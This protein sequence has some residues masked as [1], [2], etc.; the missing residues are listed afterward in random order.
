M[1]ELLGLFF[2][3]RALKKRIVTFASV[4]VGLWL[5]S[6]TL[7]PPAPKRPAWADRAVTPSQRAE[8]VKVVFKFAWKGY[9][10]NAFPNDELFPLLNTYG[11]SRYAA[12]S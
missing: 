8:E 6:S 10:E 5:I 7:F 4:L 11:N 9:Y 2:L 3:R 1:L 12:C